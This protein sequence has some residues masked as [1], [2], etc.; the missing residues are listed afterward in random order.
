MDKILGDKEVWKHVFKHTLD[1]IKITE[2][3]GFCICCRR[4]HDLIVKK[5]KYTIDNEI[6]LCYSEFGY[7]ESLI[8]T[9]LYKDGSIVTIHCDYDFDDDMEM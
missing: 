3:I 1:N 9:I 8:N 7:S 6:R 4:E 2:K 5:L